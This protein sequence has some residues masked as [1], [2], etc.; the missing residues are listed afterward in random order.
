MK[1]FE[2]NGLHI[3]VSENYLAKQLDKYLAKTKKVTENEQDLQKVNKSISNIEIEFKKIQMVVN[4]LYKLMPDFIDVLPKTKA[5]IFSKNQK[6]YLYRMNL[7]L[8]MHTGDYFS[9]TNM[10]LM[11]ETNANVSLTA[12][13]ANLVSQSLP[14]AKAAS[15]IA[16]YEESLRKGLTKDEDDLLKQKYGDDYKLKGNF[17]FLTFD[18]NTSNKKASDFYF[19]RNLKFQKAASK[20][21]TYL[22]EC[23][24]GNLYK[25]KNGKTYLCVP[26]CSIYSYH[27][28]DNEI[29]RACLG[30]SSYF[31]FRVGIDTPKVTKEQFQTILPKIKYNAPPL[32]FLYTKE[33]EYLV[34]QGKTAQEIMYLYLTYNMKFKL[35]NATYAKQMTEDLG[36]VVQSVPKQ[37]IVENKEEEN[38]YV[39]STKD[40]MIK[41]EVSKLKDY[42]ED[43][44]PLEL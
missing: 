40:V 21:S 34:K 44:A 29:I 18:E 16:G 17:L 36:Q 15:F 22:S 20:K 1:D 30:Y 2:K 26:G 5:G 42:Q 7:K 27:A 31:A 10:C 14:P 35:S 39:V 28:W 6:V 13:E 12:E 11:L 32:F 33:V 8:D 38:W 3:I 9:A 41:K 24:V 19:D 25:N 23:K 37:F 43:Y 4:E